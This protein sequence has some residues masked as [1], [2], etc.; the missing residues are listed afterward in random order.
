MALAV[1]NPLRLLETSF[2]RD[3]FFREFFRDME[4]SMGAGTGGDV[5]VV[6]AP[7]MNVAE[8]QDAYE[9]TFEVPGLKKEDINIE[10]N[11]GRLAVWGEK[12]VEREEQGKSGKKEHIRE[13]AYGA[14]RRELTLPEDVNAEEI[15]AAYDNGHL[16]ITIPR[17][18]QQKQVRRVNVS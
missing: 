11:E 16:K 1:Y 17:V 18:V 10:V 14:F 2:S 7:R 9:V 13:I 12:K 5:S 15:Q 4:R 8:R 6:L 3:P